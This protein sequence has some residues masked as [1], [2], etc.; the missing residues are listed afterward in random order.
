[1]SGQSSLKIYADRLDSAFRREKDDMRLNGAKSW[2]PSPE[3]INV[4]L[5]S[6]AAENPLHKGLFQTLEVVN[7]LVL[8]DT[9]VQLFS[10]RPSKLIRFALPT[11]NAVDVV[12][13]LAKRG[14]TL[15]WDEEYDKR[16]EVWC[17]LKL[18]GFINRRV[19]KM[20]R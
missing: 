20:E 11:A 1:M 16:E 2:L 15:S 5:T 7:G 18:P 3:W 10:E 6:L 12:V 9:R 8:V 13:A 19:L 17:K 14:H 4:V